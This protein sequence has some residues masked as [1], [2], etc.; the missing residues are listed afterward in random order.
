MTRAYDIVYSV[1]A[2]ES[3][4]CV[5]NLYEN[6]V[7]HNSQA[8]CLVVFHVNDLLAGQI[9][10]VPAPENLLFNPRITEKARFTQ[11]LMLAHI[12]NFRY[13]EC[14]GIEF[15]FFALLASN[16][17]FVRDT[18]QWLIERDT[19]VLDGL[20]HENEQDPGINFEH[21]EQEWFWQI[22]MECQDVVDVFRK[23]RIGVNARC[24]E[25]SY[26]RKDVFGRI[27][28]FCEQHIVGKIEL[29]DGIDWQEIFFPSL[30]K[31]FT[32]RLGT[33]YCQHFS[34]EGEIPIRSLVRIAHGNGE[35]NIVKR[36][37]RSMDSR[38]RQFICT[39]L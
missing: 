3:I 25:G 6:I 33:R 5:Y 36:V 18:E 34:F 8:E 14:L 13:V 12:D 30:E 21:I 27:C 2:H 37:E 10:T 38:V 35:C 22:Y 16:C 20:P 28:E 24:H 4:E 32:G 15:K 9:Q 7:Q 23:N 29:K 31:Y 26:F 17:M 11:T 1:T 19:P 39:Y